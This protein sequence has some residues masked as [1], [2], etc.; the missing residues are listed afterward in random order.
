MDANR[1]ERKT[2]R[3][4]TR[5]GANKNLLAQRDIGGTNG[6]KCRA[7][8]LRTSAFICSSFFIRVYSRPFA[9]GL[10]FF[11][12]IR[13]LFIRVHSRFGFVLLEIFC[14]YSQAFLAL[15]E[16]IFD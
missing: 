3:E 16:T 2:N 13:G 14:G 1:R 12:S 10:G 6:E 15:Y 11:A 5:I 7:P 9:V 4:W 8:H